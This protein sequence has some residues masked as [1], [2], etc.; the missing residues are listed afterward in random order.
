MVERNIT[1]C[2][3]RMKETYRF[4]VEQG[5]DAVINHHQHCYSGYE[6]HNG[7]PIFYGLGIFCFDKGQQSPTF[8]HKGYMVILNIERPN[9]TFQLIPYNQCS[10][11][12]IIH[13]I[14]DRKDFD[15]NIT[16]L[17]NI[18]ADDRMLEQCFHEIAT[19]RQKIVKGVLVPYHSHFMR[20]LFMRGLVPSFV[21]E[22]QMIHVLANTQCEAHRDVMLEYLK[23][24]F[25]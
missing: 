20:K 21:S 19:Q 4:F 5:A 11:S 3:P 25:K 2:P 15:N 12:P 22:Q 7:K 1:I 9:A 13:L 17:N 10:E 23:T 24:S 14:D 8:W 6:E 16:H 18:I